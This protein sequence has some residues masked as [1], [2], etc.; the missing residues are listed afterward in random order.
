M[1]LLSESYQIENLRQKRYKEKSLS[2]KDNL[3]LDQP[4]RSVSFLTT[5][6]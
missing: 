6:T 3:C 1:R 4:K 5:R 2:I